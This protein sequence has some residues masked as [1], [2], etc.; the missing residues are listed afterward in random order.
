VSSPSPRSAGLDSPKA[1][2]M[3][4]MMHIRP[5]IMDGRNLGQ[6]PPTLPAEEERRKTGAGAKAGP[7]HGS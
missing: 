5:P 7:H 2:S 6:E 1:H 3:G 4:A